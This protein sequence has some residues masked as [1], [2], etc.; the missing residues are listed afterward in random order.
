MVGSER[1]DIVAVCSDGKEVPI[2]R[3]G[4]FCF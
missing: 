4:R 3:N 2:M 1:I